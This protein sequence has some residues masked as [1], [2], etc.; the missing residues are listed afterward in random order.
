MKD[1]VSVYSFPS[2]FFASASLVAFALG[3]SMHF[4]RFCQNQ[5]SK[6]MPVH[7]TKEV[8]FQNDR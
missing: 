1:A 2:I 6:V 4:I 7:N 8:G 3:V 5:L